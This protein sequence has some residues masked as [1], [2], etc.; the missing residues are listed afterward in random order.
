[1]FAFLLNLPVIIFGITDCPAVTFE[2]AV[3]VV[4][5]AGVCSVAVEIHC[6]VIASGLTAGIAC[7]SGI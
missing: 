6:A 7:G 2:T 4:S 3:T 1:L 5:V